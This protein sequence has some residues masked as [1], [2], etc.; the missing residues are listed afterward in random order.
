[1]SRLATIPAGAP[2]FFGLRAAFATGD[3]GDTPPASVPSSKLV[4]RGFGGISDAILASWDP[5][6]GALGQTRLLRGAY[7]LAS[8]EGVLDLE[9]DAGNELYVVLSRDA[10][11]GLETIA[12][13]ILAGTS[14]GISVYPAFGAA[15]PVPAEKLPPLRTFGGTTEPPPAL[16]VE[17]S[18]PTSG[19]PI[20]RASGGDA[21]PMRAP[22]AT[23][24][25]TQLSPGEARAL[26]GEVPVIAP[27]PRAREPRRG[28][29][30]LDLS[31]APGPETASVWAVSP[32]DLARLDADQDATALHTPHTPALHDPRV[33]SRPV[34]ALRDRVEH[35]T[36]GACDVETVEA[37]GVRVRLRSNGQRV[38]LSHHDTAFTLQGR[39]GD[40]RIFLGLPR[41]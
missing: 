25:F 23:S 6:L 27:V 4:V 3:G 11:H 41:A 5:S 35:I 10:G 2:L 14:L 7:L 18:R 24:T 34:P 32:E 22:A 8:I 16:R 31:E 40:V 33:V 28:V 29:P 9:D 38:L 15:L 1:M 39:D 30:L 21:P 26:T 20:T 17:A 19:V 13:R 12:G 37:I 36:Y